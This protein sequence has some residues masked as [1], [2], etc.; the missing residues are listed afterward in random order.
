MTHL[1]GP[2]GPAARPPARPGPGASACPARPGAARAARGRP[3]AEIPA[4]AGVLAR[5]ISLGV[6]YRLGH[7]DLV[8]FH[9]HRTSASAA[10]PRRRSRGSR[11]RSGSH[12]GWRSR[13]GRSRPSRSPPRP[14]IAALD[15]G[16]VGPARRRSPSSSSYSGAAPAV[17]AGPRPPRRPPPAARAGPRACLREVVM[18]AVYPRGILANRAR[19]R[20]AGE[21]RP[22][23][24]FGRRSSAARLPSSLVSPLG[25][26][27]EPVVPRAV[28]REDRP[29]R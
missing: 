14:P 4:L 24:S 9:P 6:A 5:A 13:G 16:A 8:G 25:P 23:H 3:R 7:V 1:D 10:P 21:P 11:G 29:S 15:Q 12:R 17:P 27:A 20:T 18:R 19:G 2:L 22:A 26:C 28:D